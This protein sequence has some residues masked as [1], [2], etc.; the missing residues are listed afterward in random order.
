[1]NLLHWLIA[2]WGTYLYAKQVKLNALSAF[3]AAVIFV[4]GAAYG[5]AFY[6][7]TS[8]KTVAWFPVGLWLLERYLAG[9]QRRFLLI[10]AVVVSQSLIA[11]YLQVAILTWGVFAAYALLRL[12]IFPDEKLSGYKR[13]VAFFML[14][15]AGLAALMFAAPQIYLT[16]QLAVQSNRIGLAEG[17][18]YVGS[19]SPLAL[20]TLINPYISLI[21]RGNNLYAGILSFFFMLV[22]FCSPDVRR[23]QIFRLWCSVSLMVLLLALGRWSPLYVLIIKVTKFYSFRIPAKFLV[24]ICFGIAM[25]AAMGFQ[26]MWNGQATQNIVKK[27]ARIYFWI[28]GVFL[29]LTVVFNLVLRFGKDMLIRAGDFYIQRYVYAQ[30]GHPH[31]LESYLTNVRAYPDLLL[32][33]L[34][35]A[36][37]HNIFNFGLLAVSL[38]IVFLFLKKPLA[39]GILIFSL[40]FILIDLYALS[41]IDIRLDFSTYK[42]TFKSTAILKTLAAEKQAGRLQKIY[43]FRSLGERLP[44]VP[45]QN[46]LYGVEDAG[47]YSPFVLS[48]YFQT[49]G[50][51]GNV[52]DS[53]YQESPPPEYFLER[54][55]LLNFMN[56]SH[57]LS[58]RVLSAPS[59]TL[60]ANDDEGYL[61]ENKG[62][63]KPAYFIKKVNIIESWDDLR[64][65]LMAPAFDPRRTL[66]LEKNEILKVA[67]AENTDMSEARAQI[68]LLRQSDDFSEWEVESDR[69]GFFV[70]P[71][72]YFTGWQALVDGKRVPI[73]KADGLFRA[74]WL[75]APGKYKI[76]FR[77]NPFTFKNT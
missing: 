20:G 60:I 67:Y 25:I 6:N 72:T 38:I 30:P 1:M 59:L 46:M 51:L 4:F 48:R 41:A 62:L 57:V 31:S 3:L 50:L 56:V 16:F 70:T 45:S 34:N 55:P 77:Y 18:A 23:R 49:I 14:V 10:L 43:G 13:T 52:N 28:T 17:Y 32:S 53:N 58:A 8:L 66:L 11:G 44:L 64:A 76:T 39:K 21:L 42:T 75:P 12:F 74:L 7:M 47:V 40:C 65:Q 37:P 73:L 61:Y 29:G 19:M 35:W 68:T 71:E 15:C 27:A 22:A 2:G 69:A 26:Q 24:F 54:L 63:H 33:Y 5:G 9:S 36:N